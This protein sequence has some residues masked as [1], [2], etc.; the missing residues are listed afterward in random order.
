MAKQIFEVK[1]ANTVTGL[2]NTTWDGT[3]VSGRAATE[4]Q[5]AAAVAGASGGSAVLTET[6]TF[7]RNLGYVV[8]GTTYAAGTSI[9]QI[10]QDM[11]QNSTERRLYAAKTAGVDNNDK[12]STGAIIDTGLTMNYDYTFIATGYV[13]EGVQNVFVGAFQDISTRTTNRFLGGSKQVQS[14]WPTNKNFNAVNDNT[15]IDITQLFTY[16]ATNKGMVLTQG[17]VTYEFPYETDGEGVANIPIYL[18][19]EATTLKYNNAAIHEAIIKDGEGTILRHFQPWMIDNEVV[20]VDIAHDNQ[21][22]RPMNGIGSGK[23][24]EVME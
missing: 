19:D 20:M 17:N 18:F 2:T 7:N 9:E 22:Y 3:A 14:M 5:L 21:V 10:L 6:L 1:L 24:I 8:M 4:D 23:L 16:T 13:A 11:V 15:G 12:S